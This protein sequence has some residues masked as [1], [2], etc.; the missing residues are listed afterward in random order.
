[1]LH[2]KGMFATCFTAALLALPSC[3]GNGAGIKPQA[4]SLPPSFPHS[5][6]RARACM[7]RA[8][9]KAHT[10]GVRI[11]GKFVRLVPLTLAVPVT[12]GGRI[13]GGVTVTGSG[14]LS[15]W[16]FAG[17]ARAR[18]WQKWVERPPSPYKRFDRRFENVV[19]TR[20]QGESPAFAVID[21]CIRAS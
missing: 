11:N 13:Q 20:F 21:K 17:T 4:D 7:R 15:I 8:G 2:V 3:G 16:F 9:L 19:Y 6:Q 12:V 14:D 1:M 18:A 10:Y 5:F